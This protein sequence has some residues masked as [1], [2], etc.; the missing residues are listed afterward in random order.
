VNITF[1]TKAMLLN[2][3]RERLVAVAKKVDLVLRQCY[4][5]NGKYGVICPASALLRQIG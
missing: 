1:S 3:A 2:R 5:W 4:S